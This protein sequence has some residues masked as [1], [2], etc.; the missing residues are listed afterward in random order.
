MSTSIESA[1][2]R[3]YTFPGLLQSSMQ[4]TRV[5]LMSFA[6]NVFQRNL[7]AF[8]CMECLSVGQRRYPVQIHYA[9]DLVHLAEKSREKRAQCIATVRTE[10]AELAK[11]TKT[12]LLSP[13]FKLR[14]FKA[15]VN[16]V[17]SCC[18]QGATVLMFL[19]DF[20][21]ITEMALLFDVF[22]GCWVLPLH[23][24]LTA[25]EQSKVLQPTPPNKLKVVLTTS[26]WESSL[27]IPD[28]DT[29]ICLGT[30][31]A[32]R[33]AAD[34]RQRPVES[35]LI[36]KVSAGQRAGRT[37]RTRPG[38]VYRLYP[39]TCFAAMD[40][41]SSAY[42]QQ[43]PLAEVVLS[44][45]RKLPA[46]C[47]S[48]EGAVSLL[49]VLIQPPPL[50]KIQETYDGLFALNLITEASGDGT[51]TDTGRGLSALPLSPMLNRMIKHAVMLGV[52]AEVVAIIAL[53]SLPSVPFQIS[54]PNFASFAG[55]N[56]NIRRKFLASEMHDEGCYSEPIMWLRILLE[57]RSA[58]DK[59]A[60]CRQHFL[61]RKAMVMFSTAVGALTHLLKSSF[62]PVLHSALD[63]P[64]DAGRS[65]TPSKVNLLR[66]ILTWASSG[67]I[68]MMEPVPPS[69]VHEQ[70]G[71]KI[72]CTEL[73]H[74]Q[75]K[76]LF[77]TVPYDYGPRDRLMEYHGNLT[78]WD[79]HDFF[80]GVVDLLNRL[81]PLADEQRA[82]AYWIIVESRVANA[83]FAVVVT[84]SR[85]QRTLLDI[86]QFATAADVEENAQV[87]QALRENAP[88]V[89]TS[90]LNV[91]TRADPAAL[92][93]IRSLTKTAGRWVE[94]VVPIE[95]L[96]RLCTN[97]SITSGS[98]A[99]R[100]L[101]D[102]VEMTPESTNTEAAGPAKCDWLRFPVVGTTRASLIDDLPQGYRLIKCC[103]QGKKVLHL[104]LERK[105]S[106]GKK[107]AKVTAGLAESIN[108]P[109][110][111]ITP[112]W[113]N[114]PGIVTLPATSSLESEPEQP[115][116]TWPHQSIMSCSA[117]LG[118][119]PLFAAS[120]RIIGSKKKIFCEMVSFLPPGPTW[121]QLALLCVG[122]DADA[123]LEAC[124]DHTSEAT[125]RQ[126][127][128]AAQ[129]E[130]KL[131]WAHDI[132][133]RPDIVE[134]IDELFL[135]PDG[136]Q[137]EA[138]VLVSTED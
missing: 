50:H 26:E 24:Y 130:E 77:G 107:E 15:A 3:E 57:W 8:G 80:A 16:L 58:A 103:L 11:A 138:D 69:S 34:S 4:T 46:E 75:L 55:Y 72:D 123:V 94:V 71:L 125:E 97:T 19:G 137:N 52:A 136:A 109:L 37:G 2:Y 108:V 86:P 115:K 84:P 48:L 114:L 28:C 49:S 42:V 6:S 101:V 105:R 68:M 98:V 18:A 118:S 133:P 64:N 9:E 76:A 79:S 135:S 89:G 78:V 41:Y 95:G 29:V 60:F 82:D 128:L 93:R 51:L 27:F 122:A 38:T 54:I 119:E 99:H 5:C 106:E 33:P 36:S 129:V 13:Y 81:T 35:A 65:L 21:D 120:L 74:T 104:V 102:C 112:V 117:N 12:N 90:L 132:V 20:N 31:Q 7:R 14:Q 56:N 73:L 23:G 111:C 110:D 22:K 30:H 121:L 67:N 87:A 134:L 1:L 113:R 83:N 61:E 17:A 44:V 116:V 40:V 39:R 62:P 53:R 85:S 91:L 43:A 63:L 126:L 127:E 92:A 25:E 96:A 70:A 124:P 32:C 47:P 88:S 131:Y 66:L 100:V 59:A 45:A 10:A